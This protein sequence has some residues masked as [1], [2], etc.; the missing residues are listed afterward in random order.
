MDKQTRRFILLL[1]FM[2]LVLENVALSAKIVSQIMFNSKEDE[3]STNLR[4]I[5]DQATTI[6]QISKSSV[7]R[8]IDDDKVASSSMT[9]RNHFLQNYLKNQSTVINNIRITA[10]NGI[11]SKVDTCNN[12]ICNVSLSSKQDKEGNIVTDVHLSIVTKLDADSKTNDIPFVDGVHGIENTDDQSFNYRLNYSRP[13]TY[14]YNN[15]P[16]IQSR[17][18]GGEPWY[19]GRRT[20][21][22]PQ[23]W[24][25]HSSGG[26]AAPDHYY[27]GWLPNRLLIDDKI[28]PP[29]SKTQRNNE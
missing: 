29:L 1:C 18:Q 22:R 12:G 27:T 5:N 13:S 15:I 16:Q 26:S 6:S 7:F 25:S 14:I 24:L 10:E 2:I 3:R 19:Q 23:S 28:D 11:K 8:S 4:E 17:Y 9:K 20:F 21:Q